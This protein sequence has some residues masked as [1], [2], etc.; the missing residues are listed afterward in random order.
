MIYTIM[1]NLFIVRTRHTSATAM[2]LVWMFVLISGVA[3][4]CLL[5]APGAAHAPAMTKSAQHDGGH[6][7][8]AGHLQNEA[9]AADEDDAHTSK[10]PCLKVCDEGS[11]SLPKKYVAVQIDPG[12]PIIVAVLWSSAEPSRLQYRLPASSKQTASLL[13]LRVLYARLAL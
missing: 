6:I 8:L 12:S 9:S 10:Q 5:E 11:K 4:A 7:S 1:T 13:P 2:L 3:N